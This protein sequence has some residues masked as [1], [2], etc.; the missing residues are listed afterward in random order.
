MDLIRNNKAFTFL[1]LMFV[2]IIISMMTSLVTPHF[3]K[4]YEKAEK[5]TD[6]ANLKLLNTSTAFLK[7]TNEE[8]YNE[9]FKRITDNYQKMKY[10][11]EKGF[12]DSVPVIKE[13]ENNFFWDDFNQR[14]NIGE[15]DRM[16]ISI[17][18]NTYN[19]SLSLRLEDDSSRGGLILYSGPDY[20]YIFQMEK[21]NNNGALVIR[22]TEGSRAKE[23]ITGY[24][25]SHLNS[26]LIPDSRTDTGLKWWSS[27]HTLSFSL[28]DDGRI[29]GY[30]DNNLLFD[31]FYLPEDR[32]LSE[33]FTGVW[34]SRGNISIKEIEI[35]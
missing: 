15:Q 30:I 8:D 17:K 28:K 14:W 27:Y 5:M 22:R 33:I 1:E 23:E 16:F 31:D 29:E 4:S 34:R 26:F 12:I 11:E 2:I 3:I 18:Q 6:Q 7:H 32:D 20:G 21:D 9:E 19:V 24:S 13:K 10:L 35:Y 25:F